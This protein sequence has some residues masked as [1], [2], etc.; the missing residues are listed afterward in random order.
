[1]AKVGFVLTGIAWKGG[2]RILPDW[3]GLEWLKPILDTLK[4]FEKLFVQLG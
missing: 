1:M 3:N 4:Y 2:S